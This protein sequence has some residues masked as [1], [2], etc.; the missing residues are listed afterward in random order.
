VAGERR[1]PL[2]TAAGASTV[3]IARSTDLQAPEAGAGLAVKQTAVAVAEAPTRAV[4]ER[5]TLRVTA[6]NPA[7]TVRRQALRGGV[8][9]EPVGL[10]MVEVA[11]YRHAAAVWVVSRAGPARGQEAEVVQAARQSAGPSSHPAPFTQP[12]LEQEA[13][14]V[15]GAPAAAATPVIL[16][17]TGSFLF[18]GK[19]RS[20]K[21]GEIEA[22]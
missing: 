15:Q 12:W 10:E 18:S 4:V 11:T 13:H 5:L 8:V 22:A 20:R 1:A 7:N 16:A 6:A 17:V 14:S 2:E 19:R 9:V 21:R 3:A